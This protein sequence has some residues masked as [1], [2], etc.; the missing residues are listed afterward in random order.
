M[1]RAYK[2]YNQLRNRTSQ[3]VTWITRI[4]GRAVYDIIGGNVVSYED[5][6]AGLVA[7]YLIALG[8]PRTKYLQAI[9][10][11][12]MIVYHDKLSDKIYEFITND[13]RSG[14]LTIA[15]LYKR[16]WQIETLFKRIKQ[17]FNLHNFLGDNENAIR[18]QLWCTLI[19]DL[20]INITK[21]KITKRN[22]SMANLSGLVRLHLFTYIDL[23]YF[24][25]YPDKALLEYED[26][27]KP[28]L[29][30]FKT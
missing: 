9:Q 28:Q 19:A 20:L 15:G 7:D 27:L 16:R 14:A 23:V 2:S 6:A 21:D 30:L 17:N 5:E 22:W 24:L 25:K 3:K 29:D 4:D 11:V 13:F 26:P 12:R 18:I 1:D 8:N 10:K